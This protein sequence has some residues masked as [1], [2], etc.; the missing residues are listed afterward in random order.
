MEQIISANS[1]PG[2]S[3][4][5]EPAEPANLLIVRVSVRST[6]GV[7]PG[8]PKTHRQICARPVPG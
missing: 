4:G 6:S 7:Y 8:R 1:T 3:V 5:D 2:S